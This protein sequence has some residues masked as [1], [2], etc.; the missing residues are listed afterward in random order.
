MVNNYGQSI[1]PELS[2]MISGERVLFSFLSKF[3]YPRGQSLIFIIF[4]FCWLAFSSIFV[5][6]FF[7]P[8]LVGKEVHFKSNGVPV[9]A[10]LNNLSPLLVPGI[11]IGMFVLIGLIMLYFA[12]KNYFM[13]GGYFVGTDK[14]LISYDQEIKSVP[15]DKFTGKISVFPAKKQVDLELVSGRVVSNKSRRN[16]TRSETF[17]HDLIHFV[18]V[19][20]PVQ[21]GEICRKQIEDFQAKPAGVEI[22]Q[23]I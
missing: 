21:I 14:R 19:E 10:S 20:Q 15:W 22:D 2:S 23:T 12:V 18:G 4:S 8:L 6:A 9:T 3:K 13:K 7:A 5:F 1:P 17:V 16:R 11:I